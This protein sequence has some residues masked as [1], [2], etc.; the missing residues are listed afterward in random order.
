VL[1]LLAA[2]CGDDEGDSPPVPSTVPGTG[3][4]VPTTPTGTEATP[5]TELT[6][7]SSV[8]T[9]APEPATGCPANDVAAQ[10][11]RPGT[12]H[13]RNIE[14]DETLDLAGSPHRFESGIHVEEGATLSAAPCALV[15]IGAGQGVQIVGG[16]ALI[17]EGAEGRPVRFDSESPDPAPGQWNGIQIQ[18]NARPQTRFVHTVIEDAGGSHLGAAIY[19]EGEYALNVRHV[20]IRHAKEHGI[21][22]KQEARFTDDSTALTVT[23]SGREDPYSAPVWIDSATQVRTLPDGE[24]TGNAYDEIWVEQAHVRTTGTWRNPGVRYRL[25]DGITVGHETG[26][27]LTIAPGTTLAF[28]QGKALAVGFRG[29]G[30]L[31]L[32]GESEETPITLTS[33]R[34]LPAAGDWMG[35]R[36][37]ADRSDAVT[38]LNY[39]VIEHAGAE[40]QHPYNPQERYTCRGD[41][42]AAVAV[43]ERDLG[44]RITNVVL[45]SLPASA[46]AVLMGFRGD[47]TD[48]TDRELGNDFSEAGTECL[49]NLQPEGDCPEPAC[50]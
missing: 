23:E 18:S 13:R 4:A 3:G 47:A 17:A 38:K 37:G 14:I 19:A 39:V 34:P 28:N 7:T 24:Y 50:R 46:T 43:R 21:R 29:D 11:E 5:T 44:P 36:I 22:L 45:R 26:P 32:D 40:A 1:L 35:V 15:L 30:A 27:V 20:T 12:V 8:M 2:S 49:Q 41:G 25:S 33:G 9:A 48:Y 6:G 31:V 16:A 42:A 10:L